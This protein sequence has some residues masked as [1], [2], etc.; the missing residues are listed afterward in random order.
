MEGDEGNLVSELIHVLVHTKILVETSILETEP[1]LD[2]LVKIP[3]VMLGEPHAT[4]PRIV[5]VVWMTVTAPA[6]NQ[7]QGWCSIKKVFV[8]LFRKFYLLAILVCTR[9]RS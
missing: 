4:F 9:I 8:S 3:G 6:T 2:S 1:D 5:A 7:K